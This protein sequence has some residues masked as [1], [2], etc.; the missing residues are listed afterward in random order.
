MI[1]SGKVK[2]FVDR[3]Q[4]AQ[5]LNVNNIEPRI[6]AGPQ[7]WEPSL[8]GVFHVDVDVRFYVETQSYDTLLFIM[9]RVIWL[10][11]W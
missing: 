7:M 11:P 9:L 2:D 5:K 4:M 8:D 3:Y 1:T 10:L 6:K